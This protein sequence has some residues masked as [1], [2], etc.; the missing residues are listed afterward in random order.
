MESFLI[1]ALYAVCLPGFL[2]VLLIEAFL[3]LLFAVPFWVTAG[4]G[5]MWIANHVRFV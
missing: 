4:M 5:A 3:S 2:V 1:A